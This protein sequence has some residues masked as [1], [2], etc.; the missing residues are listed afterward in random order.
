MLDR[1]ELEVNGQRHAAE[2]VYSAN[3]RYW[4]ANG[5]A[6]NG[7]LMCVQHAGNLVKRDP[8]FSSDSG[9]TILYRA[10]ISPDTSVEEIQLAGTGPAIL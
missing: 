7:W 4:T 6:G 2:P 3:R 5:M 9:G 8:F 10:T 1:C